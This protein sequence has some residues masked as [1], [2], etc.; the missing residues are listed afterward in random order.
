MKAIRFKKY[1][2]PQVVLELAEMDKPIPKGNELLIRIKAS[3]INDFDWSV[4][5]GKPY[6][7]RLLFGLFKPKKQIPGMELSGIVEGRGPDVERFK[8]GDAVYGDISNYGWG[9]FAEYMCINEKAVC[10]KPAGMSF[11]TA[12]AV[13]HASLLALQALRDLGKIKEGQKILINGA[14]GGVGSIGVHIVK[15]FTTDITGVD[16][17]E[18][19]EMMRSNGYKHLIDYRK[20]D[21]TQNG[22]VYDLILDCKS[23]KPSLSYL[24]SLKPRGKY[25]TV[26][27]KPWNLIKLLFWGKILSLFSSK[28]LLILALKPNKGLDFI[29]ELI[30]QNKIKCVIDG[31]YTM[32]EIPGLIQ[33]FG[34]GDHKGKIV[35]RME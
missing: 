18:K 5:S 28:K 2:N 32:K 26:G 7:Y 14:G 12:A 6:V 25:V 19:F 23:G 3:T 11:E 16:S 9:T 31:P 10:K 27:G 1:G 24:K 15:L 22:I 17:E 4:V 34:N 35:I 20:E 8:V 29:E 13:P 21:F 30:I 33:Y